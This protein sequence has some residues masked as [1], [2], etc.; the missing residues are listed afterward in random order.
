MD[1]TRTEEIIKLKDE[2]IE[3]WKRKYKAMR[4]VCIM[5]S[6]KTIGCVRDVYKDLEHKEFEWR[7][8]Y[9]GWLE[10]RVDIYRKALD[11]KEC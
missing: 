1:N 9:N 7:S 3:C 5:D 6:T 2:Q 10:G 4:D 8:F 11:V